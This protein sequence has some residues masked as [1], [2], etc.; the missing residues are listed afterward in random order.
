MGIVGDVGRSDEIG[1]IDGS[2]GWDAIAA[3]EGEGQS[4]HSLPRNRARM[5]A[6]MPL[7]LIGRH[8]AAP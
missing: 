2:A 5:G 6:S 1:E 4:T 3:A 8:S 7:P